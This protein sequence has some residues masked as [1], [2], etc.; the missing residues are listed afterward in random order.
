MLKLILLMDADTTTFN[1]KYTDI[2]GHSYNNSDVSFVG[3][4]SVMFTNNTATIGGAIY[5]EH[6]SDITINENAEV[7]SFCG[8]TVYSV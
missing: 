7:A 8:G 6:F 3:N 5:F 4:T 1:D 2:F